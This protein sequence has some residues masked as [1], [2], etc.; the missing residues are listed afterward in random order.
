MK[1]KRGAE[2][3]GEDNLDKY[4]RVDKRSKLSGKTRDKKLK[5]TLRKAEKTAVE[6][7]KAALSTELLLDS[8]PGYLEPEGMEKTYKF[9]QEEIRDNVDLQS[10]SKSFELSLDELGPYSIAYSRNGRNLILGGRKGH[11]AMLDWQKNKIL[12]EVQ[13]RETVR[14]V[15]FLHDH[16]MW[17]AAQ[18]KYVFIYDHGG[19][20]LHC[21]K[22]HINPNRLAFL[23]YHFLLASVGFSGYLTYQDTS[24]GEL[25]YS[26]N[27]RMRS[28]D[29]MKA[30]PSNA[31][32]HLGHA[33]GTATLWTPNFTKPVVK[34]LAHKGP[35]TSM[36]ID[37][38]GKY[39]VTAGLDGYLKVWDIRK[40]EVAFKYSTPTPAT[41]LSFSQRGML[42]VGHGPNLQV[43]KDIT[44]VKQKSPYMGNLFAGRP[45]QRAAFCPYEDILGV[46]HAKGFSSLLIPGSG[47]PNYDTFEADPFQ[48]NK[49]R[50]EA[51]VRRLLEKIPA[52][53]ITLDPS[54]I[55][56]VD[57]RPRKEKDE[58]KSIRLKEIE[59]SK[60]KEKKKARGKSS[61]LRRLR[62]KH[63][64]IVDEKKAEVKSQ[65]IEE[66]EGG[67]GS[68]G[69]VKREVNGAALSRFK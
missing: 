21:L 34:M 13:V 18:K 66:K 50:R 27:T 31:V 11:L 5:T 61:V 24:T 64:N 4:L 12:C 57:R 59:A 17:A 62:K 16:T 37:H 39:M 15:C 8:T 42:A 63:R 10:A 51:T 41:T 7:A 46:G 44:V 58:E 69:R 2:Y 32:I 3:G 53:A 55:G 65:R 40:F 26:H 1:R 28:C 56:S 38:T 52:D 33:N 35:V 14:D 36:A 67:E 9:K 22:K 54:L 47:E 6:S 19:V 49:Q 43:W 25:V 48:Q 68:A 30:N 23:P 20:E 45:I 60:K 29:C